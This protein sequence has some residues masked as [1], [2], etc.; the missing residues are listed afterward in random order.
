MKVFITG[1]TGFVGGACANHFASLGHTVSGIGRK[2]SLPLHVSQT[3]SYRR[4]D[5]ALPLPCFD[6]DVV[7]H[8]AALTSD[9]AHWQQAYKANVDGTKNVLAAAKNAKH[10]IHISSSSVYDF[11]DGNRKKEKEA[12]IYFDLLSCYG[13]TKWL[14]EKMVKE[15][16]TLNKKNHSSSAGYLWEI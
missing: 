11:R 2:P 12:G 5:I 15:N 9:S 7:I 6:A 13:K 8:A 10:F 1:I 4:A 3:C 14:A 16:N